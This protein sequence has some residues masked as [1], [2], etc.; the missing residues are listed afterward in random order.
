M[1]GDEPD[2]S[3]GDK[4]LILNGDSSQRILLHCGNKVP[5]EVK[6]TYEKVK[7]IFESDG[8]NQSTGFSLEFSSEPGIVTYMGEKFK[9][10]YSKIFCSL[11]W[12]SAS[13]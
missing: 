12:K 13:I 2:C 4:L 5:E 11:R 3:T 10:A 9:R 8:L 6:P 1:F 7:I